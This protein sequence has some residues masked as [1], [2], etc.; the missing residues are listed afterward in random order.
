MQQLKGMNLKL[1]LFDFDNTIIDCNSDTY[2]D[3]LIGYTFNKYP[4]EINSIKHW[5][6][7]M[8]HVFDY[9]SSK[10]NIKIE[11]I[12]ECLKEIKIDSHMIDLILKLKDNSYE[13][14]IVSDANTLFI[15]TILQANNIYDKFDHIYTNY[16]DSSMTNCLKLIPFNEIFNENKQP[17]SCKT[18]LCTENM[19]KGDIFI[20]HIEKKGPSESS[21]I[22]YVGDGP[23]D[24]CA[25]SKLTTNDHF[26]VR[27]DHRLH[28]IMLKNDDL[29]KSIS[30][31]VTFW[32]SAKEIIETLNF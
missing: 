10:Y 25:G 6:Q 30:S 24:Y 18:K 15:K 29:L 4:Q 9:M 26:F 23:N 20:K 28:R 7:R 5:T 11:D 32:N 14:I 17:F 16:V 12:I 19:C 27:N 13:L 3:K 31:N 21:H 2:I 1:A 8:N 22:I